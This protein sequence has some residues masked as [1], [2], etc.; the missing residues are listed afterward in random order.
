MKNFFSRTSIYVG[1]LLPLLMIQGCVGISRLH[2]GTEHTVRDRGEYGIHDR[3]TCCY[4]NGATVRTK[5][6]LIANWGKPDR[7]WT[8]NGV[9]KWRYYRGLSWYVVSLNLI[10]PIPIGVPTGHS[11]V[12][13][14][15]NGNDIAYADVDT[16]DW[17]N[18][19]C[20]FYV[21][22]TGCIVGTHFWGSKINPG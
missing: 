11:G 8:E 5:D 7:I 14:A 21:V 20:G 10:V 15:F 1:A 16:T 13:F 18:F 6:G 2:D 4:Y 3:G 19:G 9:E 22:A 17:W 12:T